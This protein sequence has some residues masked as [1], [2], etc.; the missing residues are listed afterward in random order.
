MTD[1][2]LLDTH[3]LVWLDGRAPIKPESRFEIGQASARQRLFFSHM[4]M[5][6]VGVA[7]H[8]KRLEQRPDL[9]GLS[10]GPW[11]EEVGTEFGI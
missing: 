8:K 2:S 5:W 4:S 11:F 3:T 1:G 7:L 6:E 10:I 9:R